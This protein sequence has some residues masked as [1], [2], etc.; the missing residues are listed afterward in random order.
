MGKGSGATCLKHASLISLNSYPAWYGGVGDLSKPASHWNGEA[1]NVAS[2]HPGKPFVISETGA[3]GVYEWDSNS[4][5]K[6]WTQK[7]QVEVIERDVDVAL[8]NGQISGITLWH[9]FDFKGNDDATSLCGHWD[10]IPDVYPPT[11]AYIDVNCGRPG[12]ENHKGVVDFWRREKQ[13]YSVVAA[14][15]KS[16]PTP[17]PPTPSVLDDYNRKDAS[18]CDSGNGYYHSGSDSLE[19]CAVLCADTN[20]PCFDFDKASSSNN[21]ACRVAKSGNV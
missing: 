21:P 7:Y 17:A 3:G 16:S 19:T 9:Y 10:Y 18:H 1:K 13:A 20:C 14:K 11:C 4:T 6:Q 15:Y 5:D 8:G 12:G 2:K